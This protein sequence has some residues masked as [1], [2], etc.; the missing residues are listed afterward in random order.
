MDGKPCLR[1]LWETEID[2][3]SL[4]SPHDVEATFRIKGG[5]SYRGGYVAGLSETCDPENDLQM[6]TDVQVAPNASDDAKLL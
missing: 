2:A 3:G 6:I 4:Q 5:K 1:V